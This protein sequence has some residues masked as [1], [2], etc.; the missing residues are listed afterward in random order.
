MASSNAQTQLIKEEKDVVSKGRSFFLLRHVP[1]SSPIS[2]GAPRGARESH[3]VI[4]DPNRHRVLRNHA[5]GP[6]L[7]NIIRPLRHR[8]RGGPRARSWRSS[9]CTAQGPSWPLPGA[10]AAPCQGSVP[11]PRPSRLTV[12][13]VWLRG[14]TNRWRLPRV[15]T[16]A[17]SCVTCQVFRAPRAAL[18]P[19]THELVA[20]QAM[21]TSTARSIS[22]GP[23]RTWLPASLATRE[24][25]NGRAP[26]HRAAAPTDIVLIAPS[27]RPI[28]P[29]PRGPAPCPSRQDR[30]DRCHRTSETG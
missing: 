5:H 8:V 22:C 15:S 9:A 19:R 29:H 21:P 14:S 28:P 7:D 16:L 25:K 11:C 10:S 12:T 4:T 13:G 18:L 3:P 2:L 23:L 26:P 17:P 1:D 20:D 24:E 27:W 6:C 30:L